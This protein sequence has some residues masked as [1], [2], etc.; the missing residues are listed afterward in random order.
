MK[1]Y[2]FLI[3]LL[4]PLVSAIDWTDELQLYLPFN[5]TIADF[6]GDSI[7]INFSSNRTTQPLCYQE[8]ANV[9]TTCGGLNSGVYSCSGNW[10]A[11]RICENA[12][13]GDWGTYAYGAA[14]NTGYIYINYT[15]PS[16]AG[17]A[18]WQLKYLSSS[19]TERN[20]SIPN[21][22]YD[23]YDNIISLQIISSRV[24]PLSI[25]LS[26]YSSTGWNLL[27][28][29]FGD[30]WFWEEGIYWVTPDYIVDKNN[31]ANNSLNFD[32]I[33]ESL[34]ASLTESY[35][36]TSFWYKN[37]SNVWNHVVNVTGTYYLNSTSTTLPSD[38]P[39]YFGTLIMGMTD[40]STYFNGSVDEVRVYNRSLASWEIENLYNAYD[41]FDLNVSSNISDYS[42]DQTQDFDVSISYI[43]GS[44]V[45][46]GIETNNSEYECSEEIGS[47]PVT[48]NCDNGYV[49]NYTDVNY[50]PY[51]ENSTIKLYSES[52]DVTF[53]YN[54]T[55]NIT[56]YNLN[57][58]E[59][60]TD[61]NIT[62]NLYNELA[63]YNADTHTDNAT[64]SVV[65]TDIPTGILIITGISNNYLTNSITH[66]LTITQTDYNIS[67][68]LVNSSDAGA[69]KLY[70]YTYNQDYYAIKNADTR[71]QQYFTDTGNFA[72]IQQCYSDSN[73]ECVFNIILA[74]KKYKVITQATIDGVTSTA[75]S[76]ESGNYYPVDNTEIEL[77]LSFQDE[78]T[79]PD[80]YGL[81]VTAYNTTLDG[82]TSELYATFIDIYGNTHEVCLGYYYNDGLNA[83]LGSEE[84]TNGSSGTVGYG[85][86]YVLNRDYTWTAEIYTKVDGIKSKIYESYRY[87]RIQ[88]FEKEYSDFL[89]PII[90]L[91]MA[92]LLGFAVQ[93]KN[94]I[95]FPVGMIPTMLLYTIMKPLVFT[96][97]V[98]AIIIFFC[99]M[100]IYI[101]RKRSDNEAT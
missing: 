17:G 43:M 96:V 73:G 2:L 6:S 7:A 12:F 34:N 8:T 72:E 79:A 69:G 54:G 40:A 42:G 41:N 5:N 52:Y 70:A 21:N 24:L 75:T 95:I 32:G 10:D 22:C 64:G 19:E 23:V 94:I 51:C 37:S 28:Y 81:S 16:E 93:L 71:L 15:K 59:L 89:N 85:S 84:C 30:M 80:D 3:L 92:L 4:I 62:I 83:V 45:T 74:D 58:G 57:T 91:I 33:A 9:S 90:I 18:I 27:N 38:Y 76:S 77:Y 44:G 67:L 61:E 14:G 48:V 86:S 65:L 78:Y 87:N 68:Y 36:T 49:S 97:V 100:I 98:S 13:D 46:C 55:I 26:C 25:N 101:G 66:T 35:N 88:S 63:D 20:F 82:N 29:T 31:V 47:S 39:M 56:A 99:V 50:K 1:K 60:I 53:Y 11:T